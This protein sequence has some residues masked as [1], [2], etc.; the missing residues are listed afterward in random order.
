VIVAVAIVALIVGA[1]IGFM[2]CAIL[3]AGKQDD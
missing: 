3:V 1:I 2:V